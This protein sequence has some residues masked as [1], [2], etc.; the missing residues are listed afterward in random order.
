MFLLRAHITNSISETSK[1]E[2]TSFNFTLRFRLDLTAS[3]PLFQDYF[4]ES[5]AMELGKKSKVR[6]GDCNSNVGLSA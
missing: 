6:N 5:N 1:L 3:F 4:F 2:V